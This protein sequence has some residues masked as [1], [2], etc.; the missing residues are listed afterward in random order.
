MERSAGRFEGKVVFITG[1]ARGQ[2]RS[3]A[4]R[5]AA[6]GANVIAIDACAPVLPDVSYEPATVEDLAETARLVEQEGRGIVTRV[7]DVRDQSALDAA[8]AEGIDRFGRL[9]VI[10]ANAGVASY[11]LTWEVP[12][13]HWATVLDV[14]LTGV[15]RTVKAGLPAMIEAGNGGAIT[16]IS[17]AAGLR[18]YSYLGHYAATKHGLVGL[19]R[20]LTLEVGQYDIRVNTIH[21]G[22]V[23]T[24]M[25]NDPDVRRII[26]EDPRTTAA[27]TGQRPLD[28]GAQKVEDISNALLWICSD[29]A[30]M[31]TGIA[32]PVDAGASMR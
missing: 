28:G 15:W 29:E 4:R 10:V 18:G 16:F 13:E 19:M 27:Y 8:V 30:R 6:E 17:S 7:A 14:N 1:A 11:H 24:V 5:F 23:D 21:P 3:H 26:A 20:S 2:G 25:G 22:A 9:D 12:E 31:V 32:L